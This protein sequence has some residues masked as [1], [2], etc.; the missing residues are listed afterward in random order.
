MAT[1]PGTLTDHANS[2]AA[3]LQSLWHTLT[4]NDRHASPSSPYRTGNHVPLSQSRNA[5]LTS[6]ATSAVDS[7]PDLTTFEEQSDPANPYSRRNSAATSGAYEPG[8]RSTMSRQNSGEEAATVRTSKDSTEMQM[9][10]FNDGLPP[11]P[12]VKHSWKRIDRW[13]EGNYEELWDNMGEPATL[14]DINEL[15]HELDCTLPQDVR[16]S[17]QIHDG[18]ERGGNPTGI[19][20]GCMLLDCEE[21]VDEWKNWRVVNDEVLSRP[22]FYET[23]TVPSKAF[24][25]SSSAGPS[26]A[27]APPPASN[28]G[29]PQWRE[30]LLARQDSQPSGAIQRAYTHP[31]WIP[32]ARDWGGNCLAVDLAPGP[33]GKWGQVILFGRDYDC[34]FVIARSW[35]AFLAN[36]ADDLA[37]PK[38]FVSEDSGELKL[39][40]FRGHGVEPAYIDIL[41]WRAD[42][43]YGRKPP[44]RRPEPRM[45]PNVA[46][47]I[48]RGS[49]YSSP[50]APES[51]R[52][53]SPN[54]HSG[55]SHGTQSPRGGISSPLARVAEEGESSGT[56]GQSPVS[57]RKGS[58]VQPNKPTGATE[59]AARF[60]GTANRTSV[61]SSNE[62]AK[63]TTMGLGVKN[64][65]VHGDDVADEMKNVEI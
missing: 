35:A 61:E 14:N 52:G 54:R 9:Q 53:R 60:N 22:T 10:T 34:K 16:D 38:V 24:G 8:M 44:R 48:A 43:K 47:S 18:Q 37:S 3:A 46:A 30:E 4:T 36:V 1:F 13:T 56:A 28:A 6:V 17:L 12:P 11:P 50:D 25:A 29:N 26:S 55:K 64:V 49:P 7:R 19:L 41:R 2:V 20:F 65:E 45:N 31:A 59:A 57:S 23:P 32:M 51:D 58:L 62:N 33:A 63:P 40:E 5:P 15:E 42:Q 39:R 27:A 21:I